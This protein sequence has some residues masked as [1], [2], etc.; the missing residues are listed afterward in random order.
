MR[1]YSA[2][3]Q[4]A[5]R[6]RAQDG[7]E[8]ALGETAADHL[9]ERREDRVLQ[10]GQHQADQPGPVTAQLGGAFVAQDVEGGQHRLPGRG[11]H[12]GLAVE[13]AADRRLAHPDLARYFRQSSRHVAEA[14]ASLQVSRNCAQAVPSA[15]ARRA[16]TRV[17]KLGCLAG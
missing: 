13:D 1:T 17:G 11:R 10:L 6:T 4:T 14:T 3:R 7:G 9:G 2:S 12:S 8:A 16:L 15:S 5:G